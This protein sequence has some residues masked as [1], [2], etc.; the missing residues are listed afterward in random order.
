MNLT[1]GKRYSKIEHPGNNL[2]A[3]FGHKYLIYIYILFS[4]GQNSFIESSLN[5]KCI[6]SSYVCDGQSDCK[7]GRDEIDCSGPDN[8][9]GFEEKVKRKLEVKYISR[10]LDMS[11]EGCATQCINAKDFTCRSFNYKKDQRLCTLSED[12]I[13][14]SG[15]L[16]NDDQTWNY[17]ERIDTKIA[18]DTNCT[19]GKCLNEGLMCDGKDDCGDNSDEKFC[20]I[21]PNLQVRI[22]D[23]HGNPS[24]EGSTTKSKYRYLTF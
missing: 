10:W 19:N 15:M 17:F 3:P 13:G 18:C 9:A 20:T 12:N 1:A 24:N 21:Q 22:V 14:S 11:E 2:M 4:P 23:V 16:K 5:P 6:L 8:L 7:N